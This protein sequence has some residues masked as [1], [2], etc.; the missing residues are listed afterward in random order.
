MTHFV[1]FC[2]KV[3]LQVS[4]MASA[5]KVITKEELKSHSDASSLWIAI[6][7]NVYDVTKFLDEVSFSVTLLTKV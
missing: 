5:T 1:N 3:K 4:T 7:D 2:V 6:H